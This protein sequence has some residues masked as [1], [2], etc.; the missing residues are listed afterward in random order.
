MRRPSIGFGA[1]PIAAGP[2]AAADADAAAAA[3]TA[4]SCQRWASKRVPI[5]GWSSGSVGLLRDKMTS[6]VRG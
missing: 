3:G 5:P 6:F 2:A 4:T 1:S